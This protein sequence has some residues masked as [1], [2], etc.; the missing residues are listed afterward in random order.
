MGNA[1][2]QSFT[3]IFFFYLLGLYNKIISLVHVHIIAILLYGLLSYL[4]S[5]HSFIHSF[6]YSFVTFLHLFNKDLLFTSCVLIIVLGLS[7][8]EVKVGPYL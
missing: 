3:Y 4:H 1:Q 6:V 5:T 7:G 2:T 8:A